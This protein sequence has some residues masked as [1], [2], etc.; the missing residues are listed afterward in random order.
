MA[1]LDSSLSCF[2]G[3]LAAT[4]AILLLEGGVLIWVVG[5]LILGLTEHHSQGNC[6]S[7]YN[8]NEGGNSLPSI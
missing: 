4:K 5:G 7:C 2:G 6:H 1:Y 3:C 8:S